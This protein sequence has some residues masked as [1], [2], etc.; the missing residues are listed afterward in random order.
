MGSGGQIALFYLKEAENSRC[1]CWEEVFLSVFEVFHRLR[2]KER[3]G[4]ELERGA[5][6]LWTRP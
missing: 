6:M 2:E 3:S 5:G 4:A 1:E